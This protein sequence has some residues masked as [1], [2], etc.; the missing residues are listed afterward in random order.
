MAKYKYNRIK[1]QLNSCI[2]YNTFDVDINILKIRKAFFIFVVY[3][4]IKLSTSFLDFDYY[5]YSSTN[6]LD[7]QLLSF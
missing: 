3:T 6:L 2:I 5:K 4:H 1:I 7:K